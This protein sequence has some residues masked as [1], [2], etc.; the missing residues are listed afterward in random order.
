MIISGFQQSRF[1]KYLLLVGSVG[2]IIGVLGI[3][4]SHPKNVTTF[5]YF[6]SGSIYYMVSFLIYSSMKKY[7]FSYR[8][9]LFDTLTI[10]TISVCS[11]NYPV[12]KFRMFSL[13]KM[14]GV[15]FIV[16]I[17]VMIGGLFYILVNV[18][19]K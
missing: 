7:F 4:L 19:R 15:C 9:V 17:M 10:A 12:N 11:Y 18:V 1:R 3:L 13:Y 16:I 6:M 14:M 2:V 8:L 5:A